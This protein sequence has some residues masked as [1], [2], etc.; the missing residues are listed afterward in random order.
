MSAPDAAMLAGPARIARFIETQEDAAIA[1]A[2]APR[3]VTII[4]NFAPYVFAGPSAVVAWRGAMLEHLAA[5]SGL[6]HSF[7]PACDFAQDG[8]EAFFTLPTMWRGFTR[9]RRF[10]EHGGWAFVL[11]RDQAIWR[12]R[13]YAWA[14]TDLSLEPT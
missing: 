10:I 1:E 4:E 5:T 2:F 3:G 11:A 13:A 12:V 7:G 6:E 14:V 8:D 9:A